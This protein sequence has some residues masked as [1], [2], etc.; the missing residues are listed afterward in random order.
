M[1]AVILC[2]GFATRLYPLTKDK[3]K[4]LLPVGQKSLLD[5]L[6]EKLALISEIDEVVIITN[7]RFKQHFLDWQKK[8]VLKTRVKVINDASMSNDDRLGAIRDLQLAVKEAKINDD[9]I[10]LAGDNLFDFPLRPFVDVALKHR[11]DITVGAVD[12]GNPALAAKKY[13]VLQTD[14]GGKVTLFLEKPADPPCTQVSM[15]L[16]FFPKRKLA[17][18]DEYLMNREN[19]DAPGYF[20][21]WLLERDTVR[22]YPFKNGIWYDIGDLNSYESANNLFKS[23]RS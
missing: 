22:A 13:G 9:V 15:G 4:P 21:T 14:N 6:I 3:P 7:A 5:H 19:P 8:A 12:L 2:A 23:R 1:K 11:P 18:I 20:I 17:R 16:Y 10:V